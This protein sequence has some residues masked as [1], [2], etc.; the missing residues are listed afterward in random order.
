MLKTLSKYSLS[1]ENYNVSPRFTL[2][3]SHTYSHIDHSC[4]L[5][6]LTHLLFSVIHCGVCYQRLCVSQYG[7]QE[8]SFV[9]AS[10]AEASMNAPWALSFPF[11]Q[12]GLIPQGSHV[13]HS[14]LLTSLSLAV[15]PARPP[16]LLSQGAVIAISQRSST[17]HT[18]T[19]PTIVP[20]HTTPPPQP[21]AS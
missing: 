18:I 8:A 6:C 14:L 15:S 19:P 5:T 7:N 16:W 12:P 17:R 2:S 4:T 20:P 1:T 21:P 11:S 13:N 3:H 10:G 9:A